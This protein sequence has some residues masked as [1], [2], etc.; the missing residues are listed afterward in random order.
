M[1]TNDRQAGRPE[2][3]RGMPASLW[4]AAITRRQCTLSL[5]HPGDPAHVFCS[6]S[7]PRPADIWR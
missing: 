1:D 5:R 2:Y 6:T 7:S 4:T 3:L